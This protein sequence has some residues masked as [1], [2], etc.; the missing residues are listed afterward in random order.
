MRVR[1]GEFE[2]AEER[3][4]HC[5]VIVLAGVDHERQKLRGTLLHRGH[6]GRHL[7][8]VGTRPDDVNN[9]EHGDQLGSWVFVLCALCF[10]PSTKTKV[11]RPKAKH[12]IIYNLMIR[13][14]LSR[15]TS[16]L[17]ALRVS[18]ISEASEHTRL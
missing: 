4:R 10:E 17:S 15:L 5:R 12:Q 6:D 16:P 11:Q 7:H 8:E 14:L 1:F 3:I 13:A 18:T 2:V 9:L